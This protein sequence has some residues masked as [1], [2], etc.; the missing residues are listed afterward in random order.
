MEDCIEEEQNKKE[1][2]TCELDNNLKVEII[3][4]YE[5]IPIC[6]NNNKEKEELEE[7]DNL[8]EEKI[9][10]E[11]STSYN[12]TLILHWGIFKSRNKRE[13]NHPSKEYFPKNTKIFDKNALQTEFIPEDK[14]IEDNN[15]DE[16]EEEKKIINEEKKETDQE[17]EKDNNKKEKKKDE[18]INKSEEK[19]IQKIQKIK[20]EFQR[21]ES[22]SEDIG[23]LNF[24]F[25]EPTTNKW[26]NNNKKDYQIKFRTKDN[27][28]ENELNIPDFVN[29][30]IMCEVNKG[31]W[32]LMHRYNKCYDIIQ[33]FNDK[34][35]NE[36]WIWILIWLRYSNQKLLSWQRKY[37]TR[38]IY[39]SNA[40]NRLSYDLTLR[41][42]KLYNNER[43]YKNIFS[44]K[45]SLLKNIL[46]QIGKGT[47]NGQEIRDEILNV[48]HRNHIV[49]NPL[50][51][52][53]EQWHQKLH[54]NTTPED[55]TICEAVI[56]F[57]K[58]GGNIDVYWKVLNSNGIT[59]ERL[60]SYDKKI[61]NEPWY[62]PNYNIGDFENYLQVLKRV[63]STTDLVLTFEQTKYALEGNN[64]HIFNDLIYNKDTND[65]LNQIRRV[66]EARETL[67][68]IIKNNLN[69]INK[70]RDILFFELSLE[71]YLRQLVEKIIHIK[72]DYEKYIDEI[73]LLMRNIKV[74]YPNYLEFSLCFNDWFKI[75]DRLK[76]DNSKEANLKVKSVVSRVSRLL[77]SVIDSYNNNFNI[78]AKYFGDECGIDKYY[79]DLFVEEILR[80]TIF[81]TL[82]ILLKKI[83]PIIRKNA[84]LSDWLIISRGNCNLI[85]GNLIYVKNLHEVQFKK[86]NKKTIIITENV[87]GNEEVPI[88]CVGLII[89]KTENYPDILAHVSVRARNL[90]ILFCVC[91]NENESNE[92][93]KLCNSN[94]NISIL[95]NIIRIENNNQDITQEKI[96]NEEIEKNE[97]LKLNKVN[98]IFEKIYL[99][100][101][102]FNS[103]SVGEK[104][105]NSK[106]IFHNIPDCDFIKYPESFAIPF[107]VYDYFL[108][109]PE[110]LEI[111]NSID[112]YITK[113]KSTS[114]I[115]IIKNLLKKCQEETLKIK[116]I[117]NEETEKLKNKLLNFGIKENEFDLSFLSIKKVWASKYNERVYIAIS[118][119]GYSIDEI[120]MSIL[121]QKII[122]AEYSFVIHTKN[123]LTNNTNEL[124]AE[125]VYGM[126]ETLVG[127]YE[128]QSFSFVYYK[129]KNNYEIKSY[130]NKSISLKNSGFIFRSDS[131]MED[132]EGFS[133][134]GL[135]DSVPMVNDKEIEM[136]YADNQL[137]HD[138]NFVNNIINK[139]SL[140]GIGVEKLYNVEQDIEGVYY[141]GEFYIVQTRPQV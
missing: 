43:M 21:R 103:K 122:P 102:E 57:L 36:N 11:F 111:K 51:N 49:E 74:S 135:F 117:N 53:Y 93:L 80:G 140:L 100:L 61:I 28:S 130:P 4:L 91:F 96:K 113:I 118:K 116:Y 72:I 87:N 62:N 18:E 24:V 139:I 29:D 73:N 108:S 71:I 97:K 128:G 83:E 88:N 3:C 85:T 19:K 68:N 106:K 47:G 105:N 110:N 45:L 59:K 141:N 66:T 8:K 12:K 112:N 55:I 137:F 17:L 9:K 124:F 134:A 136:S 94:V 99:E 120:K 26:Y 78:K 25:F 20:M 22:S 79:S 41:Y 127:A 63:H 7:N 58:S 70:L 133:G 84:G 34:T 121:C 75:V 95:E 1:S 64:I 89:I 82:S 107:G 114:K 123:P 138:K 40:M 81:F 38:P 77:S 50:H 60:A 44:S 27:L 101:D 65:I 14:F 2:M 23:G 31:S 125:V 69:D 46:S 92:F 33:G 48:M 39:L 6:E 129:D 32:S 30:I 131:N 13:W 67:D 15:K 119:I 52:F 54:N 104:S 86:Y 109:L 132:L 16:L 37:G 98:D 42:S 10:L 76:K 35:S 5:K 56:A 90:K 126:G 115:N